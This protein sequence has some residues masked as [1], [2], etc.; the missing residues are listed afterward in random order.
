MEESTAG[1]RMQSWGRGNRSIAYFSL[2]HLRSMLVGLFGVAPSRDKIKRTQTV[3][4]GVV[5]GGGNAELRGP[6]VVVL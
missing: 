1:I 2:H 5:G 3:N 4:A 6:I